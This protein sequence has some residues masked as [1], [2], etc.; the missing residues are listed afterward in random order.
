MIDLSSESRGPQLIVSRTH[1][2]FLIKLVEAEVPEVYDGII[3]VVAAARE[4]GRRAKVAVFTNDSD[5]DPVGAC[6]GMRG[7]RVQAIVSELCG[8]R[9]DVI[10]WTED[11]EDFMSNALAPAE[12]IDIDMDIENSSADI[13][14]APDQLSLAIG[15][16]GQNVRLASKL[17]GIMINVRAWDPAEEQNALREQLEGETKEQETEESEKA[18]AEEPAEKTLSADT[19]TSEELPK[20]ES[21]TS[22][23]ASEPSSETAVEDVETDDSNSVDDTGEKEP[24]LEEIQADSEPDKGAT[25]ADS[26]PDPEGDMAASSAEDTE[27]NNQSD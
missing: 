9:I 19:V 14:I 23:T 20:E 2:E 17:T 15:K 11:L 22:E 24:P 25:A 5:V 18:D 21:E 27:E 8:E 4:P 16:Q 3:E 12:I 7:S 13:K 10:E 1:P 6:V 26:N